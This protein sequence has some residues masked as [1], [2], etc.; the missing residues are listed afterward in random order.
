MLS[1]L[2]NYAIRREIRVG[3][4]NTR[5]YEVLDG[6]KPGEKVI[7][8]SYDLWKKDKLYSET[9]QYIIQA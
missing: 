1:I 6:L 4:K 5:Y 8:S 3:R 9:N 7:V 2:R